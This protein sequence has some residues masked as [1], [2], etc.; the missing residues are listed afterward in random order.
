MR[1][2]SY[3]ASI[4]LIR[5]NYKTITKYFW[6]ISCIKKI[7]LALVITTL[8]GNPEQA[9]VGICT[10]HTVYLSIAIYC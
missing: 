9:I 6:F 8:Y 5:T 1:D 7:L 4:Y 2:Y 3:T 10:V